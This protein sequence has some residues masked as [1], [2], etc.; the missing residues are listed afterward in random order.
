MATDISTNYSGDYDQAYVPTTPMGQMVQRTRYFDASS[1]GLTGAVEYQIMR[2]PA[3]A[4]IWKVRTNVQTAEGDAGSL[5]IGTTGSS[6]TDFEDDAD[7]NSAD[8]TESSDDIL[9]I[10]S[11]DWITMT[12]SITLDTA[13]FYVT[14]YYD[15]EDTAQALATKIDTNN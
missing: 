13:K 12:P 3:G 10:T 4:T 9:H 11:A 7:L 6:A 14:I 15:M 5:D 1:E 2:V 8:I